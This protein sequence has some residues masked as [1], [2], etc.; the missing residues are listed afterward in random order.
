MQALLH[1][2]Q[3]NQCREGSDEGLVGIAAGPVLQLEDVCLT[4]GQL[5]GSFP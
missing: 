4:A 5:D 3:S 1:S 2:Q